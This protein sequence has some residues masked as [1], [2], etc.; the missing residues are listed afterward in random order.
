MSRASL[1][2]AAFA[3]A[4]GQPADARSFVHIDAADGNAGRRL[5]VAVEPMDP[6]PQGHEQAT[7]AIATMREVFAPPRPFRHRPPCFAPSGRPI[8]AWSART[9]RR[10]AAAGSAGSS[11][12]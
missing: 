4:G 10:L 6:S 9:G 1:A 5:I 8:A 3:L 12:E 2:A 7:L 11:L